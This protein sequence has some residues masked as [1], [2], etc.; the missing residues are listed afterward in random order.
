MI[1]SILDARTEK[2]DSLPDAPKLMSY[3][4]STLKDLIEI[5]TPFE[6]ATDFSQIE[7]FPTAGYVLPCIRGLKHQVTRMTSKYHSSLVMALK[8]SI[9]QRLSVYEEND[10]YCIAAMLDP[11]FKV[12]WCESSTEVAD[13]KKILNSHVVR[14]ALPAE[15]CHENNPTS[16]SQEDEQPKKKQCIFSFMDNNRESQLHQATSRGSHEIFNYFDEAV[17]DQQDDPLTY[18]K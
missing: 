2:L 10:V 15:E 6:E 12:L 8:S 7:N 1:R 3:E 11:R 5:L 13:M 17:V 9:L 14:F 16:S 18:W 4:R